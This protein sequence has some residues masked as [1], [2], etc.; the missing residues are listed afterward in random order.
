MSLT[1]R[2]RV[3]CALNHEEPDRV[4]LFIGAN[5]ATTI[6]APL[7]EKL[8]SHLGMPGGVTRW[9]S[10]PF[11]YVWPDEEVLLHLG[12]DGRAVPLGAMESTLRREVSADCIID[13]WGVTW[14]REP[15]CI[16]FEI[17]DP[18]LRNAT[19]EDLEKYPWPNLSGPSRLVGLADRLKAAQEAGYA[20]VLLAGFM[21]FELACVLRGY[22][23]LLMD[24]VADEEFFTA[25]LSKIESLMVPYLRQA[26][27]EVGPWVDVICGADDMGTTA[28]PLMSP[29]LY[30]RLIKPHQAAIMNVI[31]ENSPAKIYLHSCGNIYPLIGDLIEIGV[32]LLNPIQVSAGEMGDTERLKREFGKRLSFCGAIDTHWAMPRGT[33]EDVRKEVRRRI[34]DLAPGGGYVA[35]AVHCIQ[36]DVP[37]ENVLAMCDE[38]RKAG[39][40]P[41]QP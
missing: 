3:M 11:Q 6:L 33:T 16:Y 25:L 15:G 26:L 40:Y 24:M 13:D 41:L 37:V 39:C 4:P 9:F 31:K 32:D 10:K 19:I 36:P 18:P 35:A 2:E 8:K 20:S 14:K 5:S 29:Q 30:R 38:V 23:T 22:D 7:Y 12:C 27:R 21:T 34:K 1:P 17:T 28:A